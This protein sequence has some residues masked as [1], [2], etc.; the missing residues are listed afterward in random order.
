MTID[1]DDLKPLTARH[2]TAR[3][4][5]LENQW[6]GAIGGQDTIRKK[7]ITGADGMT[8]QVHTRGPGTQ[9]EVITT[10]PTVD[11]VAKEIRTFVFNIYTAVVAVVANYRITL[12]NALSVGRLTACY[13]VF[14]YRTKVKRR[15]SERWNDVCRLDH[16][17][18]TGLTTV[19]V[20]SFADF[21]SGVS[22]MQIPYVGIDALPHWF[23]EGWAYRA[24]LVSD[25]NRSPLF[26]STNSRVY[27]FN[28]F[29]S[30]DVLGLGPA[31][32]QI[33]EY[34]TPSYVGLMASTMS[35]GRRLSDDGVFTY[36]GSTL[37]QNEIDEDTIDG[38]VFAWA[39]VK[40]MPIA[41][42]LQETGSWADGWNI[43]ARTIAQIPAMEYD[44]TFSIAYAAVPVFYGSKS[45]FYFPDGQSWPGVKYLEADYG[46]ITLPNRA[47]TITS[48]RA[49]A[50]VNKTFTGSAFAGSGVE[51]KTTF[52]ATGNYEGERATGTITTWWEGAGFVNTSLADVTISSPSVVFEGGVAERESNSHTTMTMEALARLPVTILFRSEVIQS[53]ESK[54][55]DYRVANDYE[56]GVFGANYLGVADWFY[57]NTFPMRGDGWAPLR[58]ALWGHI[59]LNPADPDHPENAAL[60]AAAVALVDSYN[61]RMVDAYP[62][63]PMMTLNRQNYVTTNV[64]FTAETIDYV[65]ADIDEEVFIYLHTTL[66]YQYASTDGAAYGKVYSLAAEYVL[67]TRHGG[68]SYAV[69]STTIEEPFVSFI[70]NFVS[71]GENLGLGGGIGAYHAHFLPVPLFAPVFMEQGSCPWVSYTTKAEEYAGTPP[72]IHVDFTL[73]AA[74]Y[75]TVALYTGMKYSG[76][77]GFVPHQFLNLYQRY[78]KQPGPPTRNYGLF[79]Q[80]FGTPTRIQFSNVGGSPYDF[81]SDIKLQLSRI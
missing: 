6:I 26:V 5:S 75:S 1:L 11:V 67:S 10:E 36:S 59:L 14:P 30:D 46:A 72:E 23:I 45:F 25:V 15:V 70:T 63:F 55:N 20:N 34:I 32:F 65:Y 21:L 22:T 12:T 53:A 37:L 33:K 79:A 24:A 19:K 81:S 27:S 42:F 52:T 68:G 51:L 39:K 44:D 13:S 40:V 76:T 60:N 35:A 43:G 9:P 66:S 54:N 8:T 49:T 74:K 64:L 56:T 3:G 16:D 29:K 47:D 78:L 50:S 80:M 2:G 17:D 28:S 18:L 41:P 77:V 31:C 48:K 7:F 4:K 61:G 58:R 57:Y 73:Q 38:G 71:P 62:A 69:G